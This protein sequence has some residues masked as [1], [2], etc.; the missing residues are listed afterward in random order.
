MSIRNVARTV[1]FME[2]NALSAS[3]PRVIW[4]KGGDRGHKSLRG[5]LT[6]LI[7]SLMGTNFLESDVPLTVT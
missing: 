6:P 1:S 7:L 3:P 5:L 4:L 2:L